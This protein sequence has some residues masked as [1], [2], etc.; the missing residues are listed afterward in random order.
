MF[1][2]HVSQLLGDLIYQ[3]IAMPFSIILNQ[4]EK[5]TTQGFEDSSMVDVTILYT[6]GMI[7]MNQEIQETALI[8]QTHGMKDAFERF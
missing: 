7:V 8:K 2:D 4:P 1:G 6:S 3:H 5:R